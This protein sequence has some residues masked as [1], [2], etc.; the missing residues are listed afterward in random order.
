MRAFS[1]PQV[2]GLA[3]QPYFELLILSG[4][5]F[6]HCVDQPV[7]TR[8][9]GAHEIVTVGVALDLFQGMPAMF[10]HQRVET[11]TNKEDFLGMDF[12]V[13]YLALETAQWLVNHHA[14]VRQAVTLALSTSGQQESTHAA[15]LTD[16]GGRYVRLDELHGVVDRH[17]SCYRTA[18]GVDVE[19]DVLVRVFRF[20]E[21]QL[22]T[23]QV[24]HVVLY[25][26]HQKNHPLLEKAR[27]DVIGAFATSGLLDN[28]R[29]QAACGLDIRV[30]L[31]IRIT[32]HALQSLP[33]SHVLN[34]HKPAR[35]WLMV[36]I[37]N[38]SENQSAC[39]ASTGL[40]ASS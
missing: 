1:S 27:V 32:E 31:N 19:M 17:A 3:D 29:D 2:I 8:G 21:Q 24:G 15:R 40:T 38:E 12:D 35:G 25:R 16:T 14:R 23:D 5:L 9:F 36:C 11:L 10:G 33:N 37:S 13:R 22:R 18:R 39:G 30:L 4:A 6:D 28:H 20:K 26:A 7:F 34:T